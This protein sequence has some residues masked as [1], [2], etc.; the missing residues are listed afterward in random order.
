MV[1]GFQTGSGQTRCLQKRHTHPTCCHMHV[2]CARFATD[3]IPYK[4]ATHA[5]HALVN[6]DHGESRHEV[7]CYIVDD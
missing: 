4:F 2:C 7:L 6:I 3:A 5:A 1:T